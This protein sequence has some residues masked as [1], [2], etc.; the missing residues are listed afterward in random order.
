MVRRR[1]ASTEDRA[2]AKE[3]ADRYFEFG[4]DDDAGDEERR[5]GERDSADEGF[6]LSGKRARRALPPQPSKPPPIKLTLKQ[7]L[8]AREYLIDLNGTQAAIRAGY[9]AATAHQAA[10]ENLR[11]PEVRALIDHEV[12][13]RN[14]RLNWSA[15]RVLQRLGEEVEAD[16]ADIYDEHGRLRPI[17][18]WPLVWRQG[19]IAGVES[20]DANNAEIGADGELTT[21]PTTIQK[22]R[23]SDRLKRLEL[24]GKHVAV[25]AFK[26][27][28]DHKHDAS[29][30][31]LQALAAQIDNTALRPKDGA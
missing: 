13:E 20:E 12:K 26:E 31:L 14:K 16:L 11:K 9:S 25:L 23:V 5:R 19:L 1:P 22:V 6:T 29:E 10:Y 24:I 4:R 15:D 28:V 18:E 7:S 2:K 3:I 30:K 17:H 21:V 27:R 8:F